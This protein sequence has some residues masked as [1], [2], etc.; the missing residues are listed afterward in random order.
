VGEHPRLTCAG[1][2]RTSAMQ[3]GTIGG[4]VQAERSRMP[5]HAVDA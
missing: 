3:C 5:L 2:T 4:H 1:P